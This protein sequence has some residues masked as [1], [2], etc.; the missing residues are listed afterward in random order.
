MDI[1]FAPVDSKNFDACVSLSV[2]EDQKSFVA[3]NVYSIAQSKV[4][5]A[6]CPYAIYAGETMVGF[7]MTGPDTDKGEQWIIRF[8]IDQAFQGKGY[9]RKALEVL[10]GMLRG[11]ELCETICLCVEPDN[12]VAAGLYRSLGFVDSGR[13]WEGELVYELR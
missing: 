6:M 11:R 8:M 7:A 1:R 13:V 9:G 2:R 4:E 3:P 5:P 10:I 12:A